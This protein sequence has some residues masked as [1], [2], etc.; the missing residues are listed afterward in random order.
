MKHMEDKIAITAIYNLY[1]HTG[2]VESHER[3]RAFYSRN[4]PLVVAGSIMILFQFSEHD[5]NFI[6]MSQAFIYG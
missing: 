3:S 4:T 2:K 6:K 5:I 1:T